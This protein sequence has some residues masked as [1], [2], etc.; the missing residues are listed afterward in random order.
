MMHSNARDGSWIY[1]FRAVALISI[2]SSE[3]VKR[4]ARFCTDSSL[5][6]KHMHIWDFGAHRLGMRVF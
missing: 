5:L 2:G 6:N 1:C 3:V 4:T